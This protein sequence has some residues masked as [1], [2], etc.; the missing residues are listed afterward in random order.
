MYRF[1]KFFHAVGFKQ[2]KGRRKMGVGKG[3]KIYLLAA[4]I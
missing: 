1:L 4:L 3:K 2:N